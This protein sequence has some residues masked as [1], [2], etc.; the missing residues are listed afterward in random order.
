MNGID[1]LK[2]AFRNYVTDGVASSGA[3]EPAKGEIRAAFDAL[4]ADISAAATGLRK[5]ETKALMDADTA[6][7]DGTL[8]YVWGDGTAANNTVYQSDGG[9]WSVAAWY[10][11]SVAEVVEPIFEGS[12]N[13]VFEFAAVES[14]VGNVINLETAYDTGNDIPNPTRIYRWRVPSD[15]EWGWLPLQIKINGGTAYGLYDALAGNI[16]PRQLRPF[17]WVFMQWDNAFGGVW[18]IIYPRREDTPLPLDRGGLAAMQL[19]E[20]GNLALR[21]RWLSDNLTAWEAI[22]RST[23]FEHTFASSGDQSKYV[24]MLGGGVATETAYSHTAGYIQ[25]DLSGGG[26]LWFDPNHTWPGPGF[27]NLLLILQPSTHPSFTGATDMKDAKLTLNMRLLDFELPPGVIL[28]WHFQSKVVAG[29]PGQ[30]ANYIYTGSLVSDVAGFGIGPKAGLGW[31]P[32]LREI[33]DTGDFDFTVRFIEDDAFWLNLGTSEARAAIGGTTSP[34]YT[35]APIAE[36]FSGAFG[37]MILVALYPQ[38]SIPTMAPDYDP[39]NVVQGKL[40]INNIKLELP[41]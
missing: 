5:Y 37:S 10:F 11:D 23:L 27:L 29:S 19:A 39:A 40:R 1:R 13:Q 33:A 22:P 2:A 14:K 12:D 24:A 15:Y 35:V 25:C 26:G 17:D 7:P 28:A 34:L 20:Q 6:Q 38:Q 31:P 8:A 30:Y 18:R 41:T 21:N 16:D 36:G 4:Q 3:N 9:V 32:V